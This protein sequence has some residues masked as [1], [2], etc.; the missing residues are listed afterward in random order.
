MLDSVCNNSNSTIF[1]ERRNL[2]NNKKNKQDNIN[3]G[4]AADFHN[5]EITKKTLFNL[6]KKF[7]RIVKYKSKIKHFYSKLMYKFQNQFIYSKNS[8]KLI[9]R[10]LL[11]KIFSRKSQ[12]E[13]KIMNI[14]KI[15]E[16]KS[17]LLLKIEHENN[18]LRKYYD[19]S[20]KETKATLLENEALREKI[21]ELE[22][23]LQNDD[24]NYKDL[25]NKNIHDIKS[26]LNK[27]HLIKNVVFL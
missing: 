19:G 26:I 20:R 16:E 4:N 10:V 24:Y 2:L 15:I 6:G 9:R 7:F 8:Q 13:N 25:F 23:R 27:F 5:C 11:K 21:K 14:K 3:F 22:Q 17:D 12:F 18:E 1:S